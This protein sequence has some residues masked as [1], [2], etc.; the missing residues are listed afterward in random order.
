MFSG[1]GV[2]ADFIEPDTHV[3]ADIDGIA[4]RGPTP[5]RSII[6]FQ[7]EGCVGAALG[8]P[9]IVEGSKHRS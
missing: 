6:F 3:E 7:V 9:E 1:S 4:D 5:L 8:R 2:V